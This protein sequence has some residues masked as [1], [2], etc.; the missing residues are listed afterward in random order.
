VLVKPKKFSKKQIKEDSLIKSVYSARV[1]YEENQKNILIVAGSV[2]VVA[3]LMYFYYSNKSENNIAAS[4]ELAKV[5]PLYRSGAFQEAIDGRP[6]TDITGLLSISDKYSGS[7]NGEIARVLLG[8]CYLNLGKFEEAYDAFDD[9][10]GDNEIY[11]ATALAGVAMYYENQGE[12]GDAAKNYEKAA[13]IS[14]A[15][16]SVPEYLLNAGINYIKSGSNDKAEKLLTLVKEEYKT[17]QI[18]REVEKYLALVKN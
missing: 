7:E 11:K 2:I 18:I 15:N 8:N 13:K 10:S 1:F 12:F 17:S 5:M 6:G 9:Y 3:L 16:A 14:K 4:A